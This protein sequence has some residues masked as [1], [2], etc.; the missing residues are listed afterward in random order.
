M[1]T[2]TRIIKVGPETFIWSE[3]RKAI[4]YLLFNEWSCCAN[5]TCRTIQFLFADK[6]AEM[7]LYLEGESPHPTSGKC[8]LGLHNAQRFGSFPTGPE[9][10]IGRCTV[11]TNRRAIVTDA[12]ARFAKGNYQHLVLD[13][14]HA[15][16]TLLSLRKT[17]QRGGLEIAVGSKG[18]KR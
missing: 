6:S 7:A 13:F 8:E 1:T 17:K 2:A 14:G 4:L 15:D 18:A 11:R 10:A 16:G 12:L 9:N 3:W 5:R